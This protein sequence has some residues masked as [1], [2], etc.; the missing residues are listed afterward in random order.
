MKLVD[1]TGAEV[2][3]VRDN[4][5]YAYVEKR[6]DSGE[7]VGRS[8]FV[9]APNEDNTLIFFHTEVDDAYQGRGLAGVLVRAVLDDLI[10]HGTTIVPSCPLFAAHLKKHGAQFDAAGGKRRAVRIEDIQ[11]LQRVL[12]GQ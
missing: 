2:E 6:V 3:V 12:G 10:A 8:Y 4:A 5:Q 11:Y 1:K 7:E 9:P